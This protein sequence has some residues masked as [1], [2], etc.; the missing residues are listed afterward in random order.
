MKNLII[1]DTKDALLIANKENSQ[2]IKNLVST[3]DKK[4][5]KESKEH[6]KIFRPWGFYISVIE[7][8]KWKLKEILVK[9]G[10]KL[11]LQMHHRRSEHWIVVNGSAKVQIDQKIFI[12]NENQSCYI[13]QGSK[14]RLSNEEKIPLKIIEV[15]IGSYLGEDD[16][17]RF[18]DKY[19]RSSQ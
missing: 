3:L 8:S 13:P 14:H 17:I 16:I 4:G 2:N 19:G 6:K 11:S 15:Q 1:I 12:L 18:E 7:D 9:P 5:F 10:Q